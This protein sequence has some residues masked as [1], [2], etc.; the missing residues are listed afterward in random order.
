[1]ER[2][3]LPKTPKQTN[4]SQSGVQGT[5]IGQGEAK[6]KFARKNRMQ[7]SIT[8]QKM[9]KQKANVWGGTN[10]DP[11]LLGIKYLIFKAGLKIRPLKKSNPAQWKNEVGGV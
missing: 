9:L 7:P 1:V 8:D 2:L 5:E 4:L 10:T 3:K 11:N 6:K